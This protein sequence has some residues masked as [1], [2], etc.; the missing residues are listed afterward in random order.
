MTEHINVTIS[1]YW[2][3]PQI[4]TT[5]NEEKI[6]LTVSLPDFLASLTHELYAAGRWMTLAQLQGRVALASNQVI[7]KIKEESR[8]SV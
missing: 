2:N 1:R 7:A 3:N 4:T 8:K 6:A 5:V